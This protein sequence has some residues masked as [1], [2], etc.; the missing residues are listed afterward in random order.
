MDAYL[1]ASDL[2]HIYHVATGTIYRWASQD[3]WRRT[4]YR[5]IRYHMDDAQASWARRHPGDWPHTA[6]ADE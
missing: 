1:K 2:A 6:K 3:R 4:R 5:P